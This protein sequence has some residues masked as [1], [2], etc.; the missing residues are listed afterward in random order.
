MNIQVTTYINN[1]KLL[2][3]KNEG[4]FLEEEKFYQIIYKDKHSELCDIKIDKSGEKVLIKKGGSNLNIGK[5]I[6]SSQYMTDYGPIDLQTQLLSVDIKE[7]SKFIQFEMLYR[8][9]FS[10]VDNQLNKLKI[11]IRR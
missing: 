7:K 3:E 9:I 10:K 5:E 2:F 4:D 11:L 8:I 1:E 6:T